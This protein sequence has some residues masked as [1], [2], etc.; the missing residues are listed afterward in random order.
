M[1]GIDPMEGKNC[2]NQMGQQTY[3]D[4]GA[5]VGLLLQLLAPIFFNGLVVILD[6]GFCVLNGIIERC[7]KGV[8]VLSSKREDIGQSS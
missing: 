7:K 3:D 8:F 6:S 1:W 2:P 4:L 5:T